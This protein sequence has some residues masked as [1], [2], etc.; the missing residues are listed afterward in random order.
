METRKTPARPDR[1]PRGKRYAE[2][3][4]RRDEAMIRERYL[5]RF[6]LD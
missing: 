1:P 4:A 3:Y 5:E 2:A 6:G